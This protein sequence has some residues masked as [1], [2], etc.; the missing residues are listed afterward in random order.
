[1]ES[2]LKLSF[3]LNFT[4]LPLSEALKTASEFLMVLYS[5]FFSKVCEI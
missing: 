2:I 3:S 1:M 4:S 5:L